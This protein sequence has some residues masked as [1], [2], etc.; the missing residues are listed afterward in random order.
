[1]RRSPAGLVTLI[2]M[3]VFNAVLL[4]LMLILPLMLLA[5]YLV[6]I[7]CLV[8]GTALMASG[9]LDVE[10]VIYQRDGRH[11]ALVIKETGVAGVEKSTGGFEVA[12]YTIY[13]VDKTSSEPLKKN[14]VAPDSEGYKLLIGLLYAASGIVLFGLNRKLAGYLASGAARYFEINTNILHGVRNNKGEGCRT[15]KPQEGGNRPQSS[16][17][18]GHTD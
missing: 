9:L 6:S 2:F 16:T 15:A 12:P 5:L 4:P 14:S 13:I 1:M 18:S 17:G 3:A 7:S 11:M 10:Q 8:G